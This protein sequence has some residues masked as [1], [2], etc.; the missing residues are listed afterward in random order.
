MFKLPYSLLPTER[1]KSVSHHFL[2]IG[3]FLQNIFPFVKLHLKQS[4]LEF[5][6][7]EYLS[8][9]FLSSFISFV[10][11]GFFLGIILFLAGITQF[12]FFTL[13]VSIIISLF[14]F[15]QE[16]AYLKI[17]I[18][19]RVKNIE[20]NLIPVLQNLLVQFNSGV[21]LFDSLVNISRGNY[22]EISKE[23]ANAVKSINA[24]TPQI[25]KL[26]EMASFNPS[27]FFRR[28]IWQLINGMK[29]GSDMA[30]VID[31]I[32]DLLS[33]EQLLQIQRYGSQLNPLAMFYMLVVVIVPALGTTFLIMLSSF[34]SL[35]E[36]TTK[37]I[38]WGFFGV[39]LFFQ[40]IFLGI[41]KSKR[42][43]L[44]GD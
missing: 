21:P 33:E 19:R 11:F 14:I 6:A 1:L 10:F 13:I 40:F 3:E 24:G 30:K 17:Y 31:E 29:S 38:Y 44:L 32:I 39:V 12:I 27:V 9:C 5:S 20:Q 2:G 28:A 15:F 41:I 18:N 25:E 34:I 35:P 8:M 43:N 23:F 42:P 26:E 36:F 37:M 22:G 16:I 7:K 4:E